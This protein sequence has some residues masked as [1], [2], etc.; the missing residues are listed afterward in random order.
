MCT[1]ILVLYKCFL[2]TYKYQLSYFSLGQDVHSG[3]KCGR[4]VSYDPAFLCQLTCQSAGVMASLFSFKSTRPRDM[5][6]L[7]D[8]LSIGDNKS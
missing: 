3:M 2:L 4:Q 5:L 8:T 1:S 7:K 6:L